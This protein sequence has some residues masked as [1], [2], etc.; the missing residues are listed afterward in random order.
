[1][2][3]I[4]MATQDDLLRRRKIMHVRLR[5]FSHA[6]MWLTYDI[7]QRIQILSTRNEYDFPQSHARSVI[8][9]SLQRSSSR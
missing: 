2:S 8:N 5:M 1:M 4:D 7:V 9:K 3:N 6:K